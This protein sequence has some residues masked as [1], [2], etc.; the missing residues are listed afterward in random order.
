[1]TAPWCKRPRTQKYTDG[2]DNITDNSCGI[3]IGRMRWDSIRRSLNDIPRNLTP[4]H[5]SHCSASDFGLATHIGS[6]SRA[7]LRS[8]RCEP[9]S[10]P[11]YGACTRGHP[12]ITQ[13]TR[14]STTQRAAPGCHSFSISH[15][16]ASVMATRVE[17][18]YPLI[19]FTL[20]EQPPP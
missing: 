18:L 2:T 5:C 4:H 17:D 8:G 11:G 12:Q 16:A 1:M 3:R 14:T 20:L 9:N 19:F 13:S 7:H 15:R 6:E 10:K